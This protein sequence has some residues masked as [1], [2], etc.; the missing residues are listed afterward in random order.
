MTI[1]IS[2]FK[3]MCLCWQDMHIA[4]VNLPCNI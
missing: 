3:L 2:Y 1:E 4:V